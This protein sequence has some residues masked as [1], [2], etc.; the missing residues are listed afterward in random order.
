MKRTA[1]AE[2]HGDLKEG[3]GTVT[4]ASGVLDKANYSFRTRFEDGKG[5]N[6]E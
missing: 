4:T 5:T 1:S 3:K 2:W 6:P